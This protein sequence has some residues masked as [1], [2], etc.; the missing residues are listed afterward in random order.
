[1]NAIIINDD[2]G[3]RGTGRTDCA[4]LLAI[5]QSEVAE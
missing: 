5:R 2:A 3:R 4:A 1:M